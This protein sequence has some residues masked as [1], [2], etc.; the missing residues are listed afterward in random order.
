MAD[1]QTL[2]SVCHY[3]KQTLSPVV[4]QRKEA[5]AYLSSIE[6][7]PVSFIL[8]TLTVAHFPQGYAMVLMYAMDQASLEAPTRQSAAIAFKNFIKRG[9]ERETGVHLLSE[10]DR[11]TI[12]TQSI[13]C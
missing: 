3:L 10:P 4:A 12:K 5:E 13:G 8:I 6:G 7:N 9:W 11:T 2:A 1:Q